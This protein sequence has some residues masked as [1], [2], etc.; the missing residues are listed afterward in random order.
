M[1]A[2]I[3]STDDVRINVTFPE[4]LDNDA[5]GYVEVHGTIKSKSTMSCTNFVCFPSSMIKDF[6]E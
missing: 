3:T 5:S 4:P 1:S 6:G 2:E